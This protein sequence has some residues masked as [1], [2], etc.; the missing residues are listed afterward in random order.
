MNV[1]ELFDC[2]G[3]DEQ[4][5]IEESTKLSSLDKDFF[6]VDIAGNAR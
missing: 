5:F 1:V 6:P 4:Q 2:L 3:A